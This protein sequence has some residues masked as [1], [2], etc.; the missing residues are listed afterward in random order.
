MSDIWC[1]ITISDCGHSDKKFIKGRKNA[2]MFFE[3]QVN[4]CAD[5][6]VMRATYICDNGVIKSDGRKKI[7]EYID[8]T[9][10]KLYIPS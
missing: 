4:N 10:R 5:Y 1:V 8:E 7:K 3:Q 2:E 6:V 9:Y